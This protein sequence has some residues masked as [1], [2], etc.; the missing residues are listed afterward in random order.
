MWWRKWEWQ[1]RWSSGCGSSGQQAVQRRNCG[2]YCSKS[3][4]FLRTSTVFSFLAGLF[5][6]IQQISPSLCYFFPVNYC[7]THFYRTPVYTGSTPELLDGNI[8][9]FLGIALAHITLDTFFAFCYLELFFLSL[10]FILNLF[11]IKIEQSLYKPSSWSYLLL[12]L[13]V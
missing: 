5:K 4:L 10:S 6:T 1:R 3:P 13:S 2:R 12:S 8:V 9:A 11:F 7:F